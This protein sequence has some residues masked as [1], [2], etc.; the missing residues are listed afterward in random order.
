MPWLLQWTIEELV[1]MVAR[2]SE[3]ETEELQ[4]AATQSR[5]GRVYK[6]V[7]RSRACREPRGTSQTDYRTFSQVEIQELCGS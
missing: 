4:R 1:A 3:R 7:Q 6:R 5:G 2:D